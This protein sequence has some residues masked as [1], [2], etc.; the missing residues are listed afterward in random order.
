MKSNPNLNEFFL[1]NLFLPSKIRATVIPM[2]VEMIALMLP[3]RR[4]PTLTKVNPRN[5][6]TV[7]LL[8]KEQNQSTD[9]KVRIPPASV[10]CS[11]KP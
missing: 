10:G 8:A 9:P 7:A 11:A 4:I 3:V 6:G 1:L 2:Q 5:R